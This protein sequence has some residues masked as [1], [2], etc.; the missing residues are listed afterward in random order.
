[1][2]ERKCQNMFFELKPQHTQWGD[3]CHSPQMYF[4]GAEEIPGANYNV[5]WQI[6]KAPIHWMEQE[7]HFH[8]E[9]EYLVF[10]GADLFNPD[11]FDAEI[12]LWMGEDVENMEKYIIT[13]PTIVR[14]PASMWHCPLDFKRVD[15]PILFQAA[16]L[17]GTCGRVTR[18]VDDE[19]KVQFIYGGPE[20]T[21]GCRL[22]A[23][24]KCS[25][26]GK[27]FSLQNEGKKDA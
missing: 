11:E 21:H 24:K 8:R 20:I 5:G 26:C 3:W 13:K 19:G 15:K 7:P 4:R 22:E 10:L 18:H 16:Y 2:D 14:I 9:E 1:M 12:E 23:G 27:C 6:F 25:Y 17:N